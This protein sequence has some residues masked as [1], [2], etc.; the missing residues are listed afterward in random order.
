MLSRYYPPALGE[1]GDIPMAI[2][3]QGEADS[4]LKFTKGDLAGGSR[5]WLA[6]C[7]FGGREGE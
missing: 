5:C 4:G 1:D 2:R 3:T 7:M 6:R